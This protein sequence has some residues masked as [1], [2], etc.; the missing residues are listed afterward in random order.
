[1]SS[2]NAWIKFEK[3]LE[4]DPRVRQMAEQLREQVMHHVISPVIT[5]DF[6]VTLVLGGLARLWWYCDTYIRDGESDVIMTTVEIIN[7]IVGVENFAQLLPQ[8]WLQVVD[9]THI[10][11]PEFHRHNSKFAKAK[12]NH[13]AAQAR[14]REKLKRKNNTRTITSESRDDIGD[15][16]SDAS[17]PSPDRDRDRDL[18]SPVDLFTHHSVDTQLLDTPRRATA[19]RI[20]LDFGLS[21]ERQQIA[22][23]EQVD[24][25]REMAKFKDYWTAASG[26]AAR[27]HD[28]DATWRNWCRKAAEVPSQRRANG[29]SR[30]EKPVLTW[31]PTGEE[32]F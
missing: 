8:D 29:H 22:E 20:P 3:T 11:F 16:H 17:L 30:V 24:P 2:T 18:L 1:M 15:G 9:P 14:Y 27:K 4:R 21:P 28:W 25:E 19:R 13:A 26:A 32:K 31:Q 6:C 7:E 10:K 5:S 23:A 12:S